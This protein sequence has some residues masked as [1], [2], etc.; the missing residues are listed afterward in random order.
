[1]APFLGLGSYAVAAYLLR[2]PL[3]IDGGYETLLQRVVDTYPHHVLRLRHPP[4]IFSGPAIDR[5]PLHNCP[6]REREPPSRSRQQRLVI[7]RCS[8]KHIGKNC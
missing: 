4:S 3:K 1:V 7:D 2:G 6:V 8:G 5:P